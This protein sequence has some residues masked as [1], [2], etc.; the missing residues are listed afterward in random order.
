MLH[1]T[2]SQIWTAVACLTLLRDSKYPWT[3]ADILR[4]WR[5]Y[6]MMLQY[7]VQV[8][9]VTNK[10]FEPKTNRWEAGCSCAVWVWYPTAKTSPVLLVSL[11]KEMK[12]SYWMQEIKTM[13]NTGESTEIWEQRHITGVSLITCCDPQPCR[14]PSCKTSTSICGCA[15]GQPMHQNRA[16][17][18]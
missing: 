3:Q 8:Y 10:I 2:Q 11:I 16:R 17:N 12:H 6:N 9:S 5:V 15:W 4:L 18:G 14:I 13:Q 1:Y 7:K